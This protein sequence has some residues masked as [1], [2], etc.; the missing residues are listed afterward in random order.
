MRTKSLILSSIII[1]S[2]IS[3]AFAEVT[4]MQLN[5]DSYV[6]GD[7]IH[8]SGKVTED[9]SGLVTIVLRDPNDKFVML[10]QAMIQSDNS[11]EKTIEIN[12]KFQMFG[13]YNATG[14]VTNMTEGKIQSFEVVS[15]KIEKASD[16]MTKS[17]EE[18]KPKP[19]ENLPQNE[20][21]IIETISNQ[22]KIS[23]PPLEEPKIYDDRFS[24]TPTE[25]TSTEIADFVDRSKD[26][27]YYLDRYYNEPAYKSWFD[28]NYP[29]LSIEDA[30]GYDPKSIEPKE[31]DVITPEILPTAEAISITTPIQKTNADFAPMALALGGLAVLLGA[32]YGIKRKVDSKSIH[33]SLNKDM[34]KRKFISPIIDSRPHRILQTRLAKGEITLEEYDRLIEKLNSR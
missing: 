1:I 34:I 16:T 27:Q 7:P 30:I 9:E 4:Q 14:F 2:S 15:A 10:S 13:I 3:P 23:E 8:V 17:V 20:P 31:P 6:K 22:E 19:I 26:P 12:E 21:E 18:P 29:D 33:I 25:T 24:E 5:D 28:R 32:V 11:F